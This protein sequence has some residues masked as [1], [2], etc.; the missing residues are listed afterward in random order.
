MN[1]NI[2]L[3]HGSGG[4]MS[5]ELIRNLFFKYF[6]N[7]I[8][9]QHDDSA[10]FPY[11]AG[12]MAFTTDSYVV[13]PPFFPGGDIGKLA[14]CGTINDLVVSGARPVFLSAG[15]II[16]EGFSLLSL[17]QIVSSMAKEAEEAGV[18]IVTGDTKVVD[19]GKCDKIFINTAGIGVP[20]KSDINK[21]VPKPGDKILINGF[22]ADHGMAVM[23]ARE[24]L[25]LSSEIRSDCAS[26][27]N[28]IEP[29]MNEISVLAMR[30]VTRGGLATVLV[31]LAM[32]SGSGIILNEDSIPVKEETAAICELLGFDPIYVA[33]E[34][35]AVMI[36][37]QKEAEKALSI[38]KNNE[39]GRH[40]AIIG[41]ISSQHPKQV[42][43][44]TSAGGKR[45]IDMLAGQQLPRIC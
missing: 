14:V 26:L 6:D 45:V 33:N 29:V 3:G 17:E 2:L 35:K 18:N 5:H 10:V 24:G 22:I 11:S 25:E 15:F 37:S 38:L 1:H 40:A 31:E 44:H 4:R 28:L 43:M 7:E 30:D 36:V 23:G 13:D 32:Q 20:Y 41:E 21:G 27:H 12:H 39:N 9:H 8:L 42:V 16:E 19:K 34:G